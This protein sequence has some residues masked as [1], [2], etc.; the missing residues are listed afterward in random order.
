MIFFSLGI[1]QSLHIVF[2]SIGPIILFGSPKD[3]NQFLEHF[4]IWKEFLR[5]DCEHLVPI[6]VLI[7]ETSTEELL[8]AQE[9]LV[10]GYFTVI[11]I[12][13]VDLHDAVEDD[14]DHLEVVLPF[15]R[16][17]YGTLLHR[18]VSRWLRSS[19]TLS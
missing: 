8:L 15:K 2:K 16:V 12:L 5:E 9:S 6:E 13:C 19:P 11:D 7:R 10:V 3:P 1:E 18:L 4:S 17:V 14:V